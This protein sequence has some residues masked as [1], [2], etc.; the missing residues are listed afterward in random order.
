MKTLGRP[1]DIKKVAQVKSLRKKGLSFRQIAKLLEKDL[2]T[3]YFW[4]LKSLKGVGIK[5]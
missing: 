5:K 4:H 2:K 1:V 3:V